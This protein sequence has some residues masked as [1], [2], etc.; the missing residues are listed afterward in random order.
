M[1]RTNSVLEVKTYG[2]GAAAGGAGAATGAGAAA[3]AG[4]GV[5]AGAAGAGACKNIFKIRTDQSTC[6]IEANAA[7][8]N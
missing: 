5:G 1:H 8:S 3:G 7:C 4:A 6:T 2:A